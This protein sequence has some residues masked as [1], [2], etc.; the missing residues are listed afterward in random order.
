[1]KPSNFLSRLNSVTSANIKGAANNQLKLKA[2][3]SSS[4]KAYVLYST[5]YFRARWSF[6]S[7]ADI[8]QAEQ[9]AFTM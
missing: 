8:A 9:D 7:M 5:K 4:S 6:P 2:F 1:M 3:D